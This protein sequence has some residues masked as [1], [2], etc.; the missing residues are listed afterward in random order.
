MEGLELISF[1]IISA[2]GSAKSMYVMAIQEAKAGNITKAKTLMEEGQEV[3]KQGHEA[4]AGLI[5]EEANGNPTMVNLL[6]VHAE[7]Q[8]MTT[9]TFKLVAD[10]FIDLYEKQEEKK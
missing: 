7:D 10:E 3:F 1:Q 6:L 8:L 9:E 4:H 2:V 5:Q